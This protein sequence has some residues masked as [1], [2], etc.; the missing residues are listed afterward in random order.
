MKA[1]FW[2][3]TNTMEDKTGNIQ[4]EESTATENKAPE[5]TEPEENPE[6]KGIHV[7]RNALLEIRDDAERKR[8]IEELRHLWNRPPYSHT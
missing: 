1:K 5:Q 6:P 8:C 7:F 3:V 2:P 4:P